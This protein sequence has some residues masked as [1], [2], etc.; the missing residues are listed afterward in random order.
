MPQ[1][2]KSELLWVLHPHAAVTFC[3][4]RL[5]EQ[6]FLRRVVHLDVV[7]VR[8]HEFDVAEHVVR[9]GRLVDLEIADVHRVPVDGAGIDITAEIFDAQIVTLDCSIRRRRRTKPPPREDKV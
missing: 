7:L 4:D 1:Q 5:G 8:K 2:D 3:P 6:E 9:S